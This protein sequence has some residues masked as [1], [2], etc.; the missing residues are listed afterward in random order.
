MARRNLRWGI[1]SVILPT[2]MLLAALP[3]TTEVARVSG[4]FTM[5]YSQQ[6]PLPTGDQAAPVVLASEAKGTNANTGP[7]EYMDGAAIT[8]VEIADLTQGNGPHQ[9]YV[10]FAKGGE[11]TLNRFSGR[12]TTRLAAQKQPITTF[13]GSWSKISGTGRYAGASGQGRYKGRM[14]SPSDFIVEWEGDLNLKNSSAS[15]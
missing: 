2:T 5:K 9:G 11:T 3:A 12:V 10:T 6:H 1:L 15:R 13:E 7:T 8:I 4:K 14:L